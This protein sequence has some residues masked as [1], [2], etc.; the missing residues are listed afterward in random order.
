MKYFSHSVLTILA[1]FAILSI[2]SCG[3]YYGK[4]ISGADYVP[5]DHPWS[6]GEKVTSNYISGTFANPFVYVPGDK[7]RMGALTYYKGG[8]KDGF[9]WGWIGWDS[10]CRSL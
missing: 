2:T 10:F 6:S 5:L 8:A 4:G 9:V 7:S 1:T 3:T